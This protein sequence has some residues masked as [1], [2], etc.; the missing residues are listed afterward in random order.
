MVRNEEK[1]RHVE[2]WR[3]GQRET[4]G[5]KSLKKKGERQRGVRRTKERCS[6]QLREK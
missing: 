4:G 5:E 1:Q 3:G 2:S 6:E